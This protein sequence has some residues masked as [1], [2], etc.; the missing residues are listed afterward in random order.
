MHWFLVDYAYF[1]LLYSI[2]PTRI[3]LLTGNSFSFKLCLLVDFASLYKKK[4]CTG[5]KAA[6]P[7]PRR[8]Q[9]RPLFFILFFFGTS[10]SSV[11][12]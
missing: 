7:G 11:F 6:P 9:Y 8:L 1:A 5:N 4:R 12:F 10:S 2:F 3:H